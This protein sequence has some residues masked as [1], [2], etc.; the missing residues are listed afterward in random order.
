MQYSDKAV[1]LLLDIIR[2]K[3][4]QERCIIVK[5]ELHRLE[6]LGDTDSTIS[7]N[8]CAMSFPL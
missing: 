7:E 5:P 8:Q 1:S 3:E 2:G 4:K 6:T